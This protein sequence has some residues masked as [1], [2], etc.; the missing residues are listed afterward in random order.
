M[1]QIARLSNTKAGLKILNEVR[2]LP[3]GG[4]VAKFKLPKEV[5]TQLFV[6]PIPRNIHPVHNKGRR[7][8]RAKCILDKLHQQ[9]NSA[10]FVDA[11]S[12]GSGNRYAIAVVDETGKLISAASLRTSSIHAAEEASIALAITMRR[13]STIFSDSRTAIRNYSAGSVSMAAHKLLIKNSLSTHHSENL[14][15]THLVWF[16][17]HQGHS[18]SPNGCN[19]NE[20][21]HSAVRDLTCRAPDQEL[22]QDDCCSYK[23]PLST[24]HEITSH[25]RDGRRFF[26]PPHQKLTRAQAVTLRLIQ[27]K[28]YPTPF[29]LNKIDG[30]FPAECKRCGHTPCLL[31]HMFWLCPNQRASDLNSEEDWSRRITSEVLQDQLLAVR[32]AHAIGKA[33]GLPV[34]TWA[35]PPT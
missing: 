6:D 12:Y 1:S 23:D 27:T 9:Q 33:F 13:S 14:D 17:A 26:P 11:T 21:A 10:L 22:L 35:E 8:A 32:R 3:R 34:P 5:E 31:D 15:S 16:P 4:D 19:P 24:F 25:Y 2:I 29:V 20:Q 7:D 28:S 30:D 18:V